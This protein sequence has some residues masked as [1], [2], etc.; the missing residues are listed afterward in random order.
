VVA[1]GGREVL[2][3]HDGHL[4]RFFGPIFFRGKQIFWRIP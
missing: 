3:A 2:A 1:E 4:H